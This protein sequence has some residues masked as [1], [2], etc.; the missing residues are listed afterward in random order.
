MQTISAARIYDR[1]TRIEFAKMM[2]TYAT[3]ILGKVA[4]NNKV[5]AF[6]DLGNQSKELRDFAILSCKLGIMGINVGNT[7]RPNDSLTR[8]ETASVISR[9]YGWAVDGTPFYINHLAIMKAK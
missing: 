7:F 2:S 8:G 3:K 6:T 4:D 1:V 5:C 9:L